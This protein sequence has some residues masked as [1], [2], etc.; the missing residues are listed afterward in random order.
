MKMNNENEIY[1]YY[2]SY[3]TQISAYQISWIPVMKNNIKITYQLARRQE[4]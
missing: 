3:F 2:I 1:I 4:T